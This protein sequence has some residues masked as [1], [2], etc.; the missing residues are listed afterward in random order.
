VGHRGTAKST[1]VRA[2]AKLLPPMQVVEGCP[3]NC[4]PRAPDPNCPSCSIRKTP[5]KAVSRPVPVIDLPLGA[6]EDRVVTRWTWTGTLTGEGFLG[7]APRGQLFL[8]FVEN[9][10]EIEVISY[11]EDDGRFEVQLVKGYSSDGER[12]IVYAKRAVCL[13]CHQNAHNKLCCRAWLFRVQM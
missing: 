4:D 13:S 12:K 1:A 7:I 11:N 8:G 10:G 9:A 5:G 3:Y 6:T 2:L